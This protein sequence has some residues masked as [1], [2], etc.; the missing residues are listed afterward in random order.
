MKKIHEAIRIN[1][2]HPNEKQEI[3]NLAEK[4][5]VIKN[6]RFGIHHFCSPQERET[7]QNLILKNE[8]FVSHFDTHSTLQTSGYD[9]LVVCK[10]REYY[11]IKWK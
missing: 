11:L 9:A 3:L 8:A 10:N 1:M 6:N 2:L 5:E 4:T 7:L